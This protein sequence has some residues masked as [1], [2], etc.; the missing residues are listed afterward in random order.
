MQEEALH[1][2]HFVLVC[3]LVEPGINTVASEQKRDQLLVAS[4]NRVVVLAGEVF[5]R[6][7]VWHACYAL[8]ISDK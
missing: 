3:G 2:E 7:Q 8:V 6:L 5:Q 1:I 4:A